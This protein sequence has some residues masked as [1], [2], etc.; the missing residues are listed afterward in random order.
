MDLMSPRQLQLNDNPRI[1][2]WKNNVKNT[3]AI[4]VPISVAPRYS[5]L[6]RKQSEITASIP[7]PMY[8][9]GKEHH[10]GNRSQRVK[11]S[12]VSA[13]E[14]IFEMAVYRKNS[15]NPIRNTVRMNVSILLGFMCFRVMSR[16][17]IVSWHRSNVKIGSLPRRKAGEMFLFSVRGKDVFSIGLYIFNRL[18]SIILWMVMR[19]VG[20]GSFCLT[21]RKISII[22]RARCAGHTLFSRPAS[23]GGRT[24]IP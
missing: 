22:V 19:N 7:I 8:A 1:Q 13:T 20:S 14:V 23:R 18:I 16:R 15:P 11:N 6:P 21:V 10:S 24:D 5:H 9:R 4:T 2:A 3:V 17:L 12:A